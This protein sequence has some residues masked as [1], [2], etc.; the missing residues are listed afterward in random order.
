MSE[1]KNI[2]IAAVL[3]THWA[4]Q[5]LQKAGAEPVIA[6]SMAEHLVAADLLGFRTHGLM[7]LG[8]NVRCLQQGEARGAGTYVVE[9]QRAAMQLW[10]ADYLSGLYV[11]PQAVKAAIAM[12]KQ[13]GTGTVVIKRAQHVAAL[14]VY[15]EHAIHAGM[16]IQLLCATPGQQVV[17]PYGAKSAWFSPNPFAIGV[18]TQSQPILFDIS[19]SMTA[20]GKVRKAIA[21]KQPLPYPA[22]ITAAGNYTTD[23]ESFL[24][25]P[26]SVLAPLGGE[27]LGYK[28]SGLCLY[29]ELWTMALSQLGRH[30]EQAGL[31]AN[32]VWIQVIDPAAFGDAEAF[33]TQAQA[34][35]DGIK[36]ATPIA[37]EQLVRVPGEGAFKLRK[38]QQEQGIEYS[39][40][41][42]RQLRKVA[43]ETGVDLPHS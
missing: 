25:D 18:P 19:L 22:L 23:A 3:A 28:G 17:A 43:V 16:M 9:R 40:A 29:S 6:A 32:T 21:E 5:C 35:V 41:L 4:A 20:A 33:K 38:M 31:D 12:A 10:D 37:P 34:M 8:Y 30:Q 15:L 13:C 2:Y 42:W 27:L 1:H 24:A 26:A 11:V 36:S 7:R 14:V 39:D